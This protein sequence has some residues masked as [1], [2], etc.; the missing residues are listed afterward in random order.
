M[1][2]I[3]FC[4][5]LLFYSLTCF[6]Q[7]PISVISPQNG[8]VL[9]SNNPVFE[10]KPVIDNGNEKPVYH[11]RL[12]QVSKSD[13][14]AAEFLKTPVYE[15]KDI[16]ET[17]FRY[18]GPALDLTK[19]YIWEV[20]G[21]GGFSTGYSTFSWVFWNWCIVFIPDPLVRVC[22]NQPATINIWKI[23][24][25][26]WSQNYTWSGPGGP[27]VSGT[28]NA[29]FL[30]LTI[31]ASHIPAASGIYTYTFTTSCSAP[32]TFQIQ[33]YDPVSP[34][35]ATVISPSSVCDGETAMINV[36]GITAGAN[37]KWE[38]KDNCHPNW[39]P[40]SS[41]V[42]TPAGMQGS[43]AGTNQQFTCSCTSAPWFTTRQFRAHVGSDDPNAPGCASAYTP[44]GTLKIY[45]KPSLSIASLPAGPIC[46]NSTPVTFTLNAT[47]VGNVSWANTP[48]FTIT[49]AGP[50]TW[51]A[52]GLPP[53]S[54]D[55]IFTATASTGGPCAAVT[56][57]III[58]VDQPVSCIGGITTNRDP[59][60]IVCPPDDAVLMLN[61]C[62]HAG[63]IEWA[64]R[65]SASGT[66][67]PFG[68]NG[69][70][71]NTNSGSL[72]ITTHTWYRA[73]VHS[74][75]DICPPLVLYTDIDVYPA[76]VVP[77]VS[78]AGPLT[79]CEG[80][81]TPLLTV[82]PAP[83]SFTYTWMHNGIPASPPN[84]WRATDAGSWWVVSKD[85]CGRTAISNIVDIK[86]DV[87]TITVGPCCGTKPPT[88]FVVS[89]N[90]SVNGNFIPT[91]QNIQWR[92]GSCSGPLVS[93]GL[94]VPNPIAGHTYC[95]RVRRSPNDCWS[96][97]RCFV[98][99]AKC[100]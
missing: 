69:T 68:G 29:W 95:V 45:C 54:G 75:L 70:W 47:A 44:T 2:R 11:F 88:L 27:P 67:I 17:F 99:P 39:T 61:N 66:W 56:Q 5:L 60:R 9:K 36:P 55:I 52:T 91:A 6:G 94:Q 37:I 13:L 1:N 65:K 8:I 12:Y 38:F 40:T 28:S 4:F 19:G 58:K 73:T 93:T 83:G 97:C 23:I 64:Y 84:V 32:V 49:P 7:R 79:V 82:S 18:D 63:N 21:P 98:V 24:T 42:S 16:I 76:P 48:G 41:L 33:V 78:P 57:S 80:A 92:D 20:T 87:I 46:N 34:G 74:K 90:S 100:K 89:A 96:V 15:K 25:G 35:V 3:F 51:T 50:G 77:V 22:T 81:T 14:S 26:A 71:Q 53:S 85:N 72:D 31:P 59:S 86:V 30:P 10:W 62:Q 43:P